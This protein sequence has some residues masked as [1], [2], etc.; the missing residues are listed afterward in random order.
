M[1]P[2]NDPQR[3]LAD[4]ARQFAAGRGDAA[5][6]RA[7]RD[8]VPDF[9]RDVW[10]EMAELGWLSVLVPEA[11]GG[12]GNGLEEMGQL[13]YEWGA[14]GGPEPLVASGVLALTMLVDADGPARSALLASTLQGAAVPALAWM[15]PGSTCTSQAGRWRVSGSARLV[16]PC[17]ATDLLLV[18]A[19][20]ESLPALCVSADAAGLSVRREARADGTAAAWLKFDGAAVPEACV[21][22]HPARAATAARKALDFALIM[23]AVSMA[24]TMRSMNALTQEYLRTRTQFGKPIGAFQALQHK[25]VDMHIAEQMARDVAQHACAKVDA[26][27]TPDERACLASRAKARAGD[28]LDR[29]ARMAVQL[30]GA[31]GFTDEYDLSLHLNRALT[32]SA[33]L[34]NADEHVRRYAAHAAPFEAA[35]A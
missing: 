7:C 30:H 19:D 11:D 4:A 20:G 26:G 28:A 22:A 3:M 8:R 33:W 1:R 23:A 14:A 13:V 24:G 25:A 5:R 31:V 27:C 16:T 18:F 6:V 21:V 9:D 17:D 2:H 34:G 35:N 10:R 12:L 32:F 29:I 15:D